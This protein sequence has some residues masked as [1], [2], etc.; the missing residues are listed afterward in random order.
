MSKERSTKIGIPDSGTTHIQQETQYGVIWPDGTTTWQQ[1]ERGAGMTPIHISRLVL[2]PLDP[3]STEVSKW[4]PKYWDDL[5]ESR[6][7]SAK[8][9]FNEYKDM[10][11]FI[12]RTIVLS[13]TAAEP[14]QA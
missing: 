13:V 12:K 8:L 4:S 5:L 9:D 7:K 1:V 11:R 14:V 3:A 10:H 2:G 6:S